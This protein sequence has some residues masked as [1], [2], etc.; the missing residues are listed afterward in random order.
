MMF[1]KLDIFSNSFS[2]SW[3]LAILLGVFTA[4]VAAPLPTALDSLITETF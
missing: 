3:I 4:E 1:C 2:Q